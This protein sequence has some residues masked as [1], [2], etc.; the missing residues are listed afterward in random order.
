LPGLLEEASELVVRP[1]VEALAGKELRRLVIAPNRALNVLPLH[2]CPMTRSANGDIK[3]DTRCL[4]D[5]FEIV[6][7]PSFSV[8]GRCAQRDRQSRGD[9][10]VIGN[11][12]GDLSFADAE[13]AVSRRRYPRCT[14]LWRSAATKK[15]LFAKSASSWLWFYAGHST[16][17]WADQ[18]ASCILLAGEELLTVREI[19]AKLNLRRNFLV[20]LNSCES[21]MSLPERLDDCVTLPAAFLSAGSVCVVSSLWA[22]SDLSAALL[23]DRFQ[24]EWQSGKSVGA[25]L[26]EAVRWL[27]DDI[28]D[29]PHLMEEILPHF[30]KNVDDPKIRERCE[31]KARAHAENHANTPP[32]ASP[33]HWAVFTAT[34]LAY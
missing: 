8:L 29:G 14:E 21:G 28:R 9:T 7:S 34:G 33:A 10:L 25:S 32:F 30:L 2:A 15:A 13:V 27:R 23:M 31:E 19:F 16:F 6:Y 5:T 11:P 18:S 1:L 12:T 17:N 22:V 20:I 4:G 3:T 24:S 26:R